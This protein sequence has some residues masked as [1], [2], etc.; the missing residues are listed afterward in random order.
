[1]SDQ[2]RAVS[3]ELSEG[4]RAEVRP[5]QKALGKK[6]APIQKGN[7]SAQRR[8]DGTSQ[9]GASPESSGSEDELALDQNLIAVNEKIAAME[10]Q[11]EADAEA[12][13]AEAQ[14]QA[15]KAAGK[16]RRDEKRRFIEERLARLERLQNGEPELEE[17]RSPRVDDHRRDQARDQG[18]RRQPSVEGEAASELTPSVLNDDPDLI[19]YMKSR[20]DFKMETDLESK[21][22]VSFPPEF[23]G[24][25]LAEYHDWVS[26]F[27]QV[28]RTKKWTYS[29]H[30][31]RIN[32]AACYLGAAALKRW[33]A[34]LKSDKPVKTW[35][36]F[37]TWLRS[38]LVTEETLR[39]NAYWD[40]S[41]LELMDNE[42]VNELHAR[43][44]EYE[45]HLGKDRDESERL[46]TLENAIAGKTKLKEY[47][48]AELKN[49]ATTVDEWLT[50]AQNAENDLPLNLRPK[51]V[52][53]GKKEADSGKGVVSGGSGSKDKDSK[54]SSGGSSARGGRGGG[55]GGQK[56]GADSRG[57][58]PR[59]PKKNKGNQRGTED[60]SDTSHITCYKCKKLGHYAS[61]CP[62]GESSSLEEAKEKA[63][64]AQSEYSRIM[65]VEAKK[66]KKD[67]KKD[68]S[69]KD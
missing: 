6:S 57:D 2:S 67:G 45:G 16:L 41:H 54:D 61:N 17:P 18:R 11:L 19:H 30:S 40:V 49:P 1:M 23:K 55:R 69:K 66:A 42:K 52:E 9:R 63:R 21:L 68:E 28:F 20:K 38:T 65:A 25:D 51:G 33:E 60:S 5:S 12:R 62:N 39:K 37:C 10:R 34:N 8:R 31:I 56:R 64:K 47:I 48:K 27:E 46:M 14:R 44:V 50:A 24:K 26:K 22:R 43:M 3:R 59:D 36:D 13:A 29:K 15:D 53:H 58:S 32:A 7:D 35:K 4:G